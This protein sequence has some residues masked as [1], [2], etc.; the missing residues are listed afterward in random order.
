ML[1]RF[2]AKRYDGCYRTNTPCPHGYQYNVGSYGC[3]ICK[4]C[5]AIDKDFLL[6][7]CKFEDNKE[8]NRE[9]KFIYRNVYR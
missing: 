8:S 5:K 4:F 1:I 2:E 3:E 9:K 6:V 7:N